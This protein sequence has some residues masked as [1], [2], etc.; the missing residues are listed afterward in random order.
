MSAAQGGAPVVG[1]GGDAR[2]VVRPLAEQVGAVLDGAP[3]LA[4]EQGVH[5]QAEG[6]A[7]GVEAG[8]L[9][10]GD[11]GQPQLVRG[12]H[13]AQSADVDRSVDPRGV[14]GEPV[15]EAG[16]A[17]EIVDAVAAQQRGEGAG[18]VQVLGVAV[19]LPEPGDALLGDHFHDQPGV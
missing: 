4:A 7:E 14:H 6:F 12:L 18:E 9:E 3:H 15:G 19:G 16:Q 17:V 11:D 2:G 5:R 8:D 1:L 13:A 10:G